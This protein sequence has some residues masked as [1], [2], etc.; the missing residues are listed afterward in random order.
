MFILAYFEAGRP[1]VEVE[2]ATAEM[3]AACSKALRSAFSV[4]TGFAP[5][6]PRAAY[7]AIAWA[8]VRLAR[9]GG[10]TLAPA[11]ACVEAAFGSVGVDQLV[12]H[13]PW[14]GFAA[15]E[16]AG[17]Q[18]LSQR[19]AL[20]QMRTL[21]FEHQ[22]SSAELEPYDRDFAGGIVFTR[23]RTPLPTWQSARPMAFVTAMIRDTRL[24]PKEARATE[25]IRALASLRFLR[26]LTA[27]EASLFTAKSPARARWGVRSALWDQRMPP[28][29][30]ALTLIAVCEA[31][32]TV[33]AM[34]EN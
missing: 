11:R 15:I 22:I 24:T 10:G 2:R 26:Q 21:V 29:A 17:E 32:R 34:D 12:T 8:M 28:D 27:D 14:L 9:D 5:D 6:V 13:M 4:E 25:L 18:S 3:L 16:A 7:G 33:Q 23:A 19:E 31:L 1:P 20:M 30:T